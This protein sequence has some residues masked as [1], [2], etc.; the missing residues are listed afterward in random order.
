MSKSVPY[1]MLRLVPLN[2]I[3]VRVVTAGGRRVMH[4]ITRCAYLLLLIGFLLVALLMAGGGGH[5]SLSELAKASTRVF[6]TISYVQLAMICLLAPI[7]TAGAITQE[8]DSRTYAILLATPLSNTQIVLGSLLSRLYYV[9]ALLLSGVPVFA[10]TLFYGGVT[11]RNIALSFAIAMTTGLLMGSTAI[12]IAVFRLGT[13][14]TVF[15]FYVFNALF[16]VGL[17]LVDDNIAAGKTTWLTGMHP[18]LALKSVV[19]PTTYTAPSATSLSDRFILI[20][21]YLAYP[22]YTYVWMT[23][24]LSLLMVIPSAIV[25]RRIAQFSEAGLIGYFRTLLLPN[26]ES[27]GRRARTV[28]ANPIAWREAATRAGMSVRGITRWTTIIVG[29]IGAGALL[30]FYHRLTLDV[31]DPETLTG[32]R[33]DMRTWLFGL[34]MLEFSVALLVATNTSASAVTRERESQTLDLLLVTP[35]TSRYYIWGKLRGLVSF[36]LPF[37]AV[38]AVTVLMV[39]LYEL[40]RGNLF[41]D[42]L[43][44]PETLITL[45]LFLTVVLAWACM[46]GL[47][48]SLKWSK[49][50]VA[51]MGSVGILAGIMTVL[52]V[53]GYPAAKLPVFGLIFSAF[54]PFQGIGVLL[55]PHVF[56]AASFEAAGGTSGITD[57]AARVVLFISFLT[58]AVVYC[59][60]VWGMYRS[61]VKNFDMI[62]RRQ[63]Q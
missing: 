60:I 39:L 53:C 17:Y 24:L 25:L 36:M 56:A 57:G 58:S 38:P 37:A 46:L 13:G 35:I 12:A 32:I 4:L 6:A 16:L 33:Q 14:K 18:F 21:W 30:Y 8:R 20:R 9:A 26:R 29:I 55:N 48:V 10:I 40:A 1:A 59:L 19:N 34:V 22:A 63:H 49:T 44:N 15:W 61:M 51:V 54:S 11:L 50:I 5:S 28:W 52:G 7:F 3:F 47:Q 23:F 31:T 2:P 41:D 62:I 27:R 43:V 42:P 45:P